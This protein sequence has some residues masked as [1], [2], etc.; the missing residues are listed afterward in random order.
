MS[1]HHHELPSGWVECAIGDITLSVSTIDQRTGQDRIVDY[2]EISSIDNQRNT[3][4]S[5]KRHR[6]LDAPS[7]A[8]QIV[9]TGDV[10]FSTV[11]PY[12]R[13]IAQVPTK[14]DGQIASTG[15]AV[16][17]P[18]EGIHPRFLFYKAVSLDFV[19]ALSALQYGV[20]YPAVTEDQVRGQRLALPPTREQI[21]IVAKL[22]ELLSELD[23]GAENLKAALELLGGYRQSL[24][25]H[26][27][28]G[29]LTAS[30]RDVHAQEVHTGDELR[31]RVVHRRKE[32]WEAFELR[33]LKTAGMR[34]AS[35]RWKLRYKKP[36]TFD[37]VGLPS[38]PKNWCWASLDELVS[39][40]PHS[41]Q[42][43]P[44]GSNL[45]HAEFKDKGVLVI[46]IDNVLDGQFSMGS[47]HRISR[48]KFATLA[49]Y[50]A[51]AG[52]LLVTVMASLGRSCVVPRDLEVAIITK[53]VYRISMEQ[54][55]VLPEFFNLLL[56]SPTTT[57]S[58]MFKN[59]QGQTRPG[60]NS[61]ILRALPV[62]LCS[63]EEQREIVARVNHELE[64]IDRA[65]VSINEQLQR[66][67]SLRQ[68]ILQRAFAGQLL[69]QDPSDE[70]ASTLLARLRAEGAPSEPHGHRVRKKRKS[71]A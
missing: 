65:T 15:F 16:L 20:S 62:P 5:V 71:A 7:R 56:Q 3:I 45:K 38:L 1:A 19:N 22:E 12:L 29:R 30:W 21:R 36:G 37:P 61:T 46:G 25:K 57:R 14:Y 28:E 43:G 8:R 49:K 27:F 54:D 63:I 60:L 69:H 66:T 59:A 9:R 64:S 55:L 23:K 26:A 68:V 67:D 6:I 13:N 33:R 44:F 50:R 47:Q 58:R 34:P 32:E 24:L 39:G 2:I 31:A 35:D 52:D 40:K 11:R 17:R 51:R 48:D 53:H 42:S 4:A 18:A 70:P 10:L 41:M